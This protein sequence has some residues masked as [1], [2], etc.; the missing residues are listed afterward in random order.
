[1]LFIPYICT[2]IH[3]KGVFTRGSYST[4]ILIKGNKNYDRSKRFQIQPSNWN[5]INGSYNNSF[6]DNKL[7]LNTIKI[8]QMALATIAAIIIAFMIINLN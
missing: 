3:K 5:S 8:L 1:L 2:V 6:Y 7:K 4:T